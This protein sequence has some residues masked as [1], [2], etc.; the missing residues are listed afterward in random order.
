MFSFFQKSFKSV[1]QKFFTFV[2]LQYN[3]CVRAEQQLAEGPHERRSRFVLQRYT[4]RL[5]R[6]NVNHGKKEG[7]PVVVRFQS[8]HID[9]IRLPLL[10]H[11]ANDNP[12]ALEAS[13]HRFVK[14]IRVLPQRP[15]L[16]IVRRYTSGTSQSVY[17]P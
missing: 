7:R 15:L 4:P 10:I 1:I 14:S 13:S 6:K 9:E 11:P 8:S 3:R 2:G 12:P 16:G 5:L 17:P